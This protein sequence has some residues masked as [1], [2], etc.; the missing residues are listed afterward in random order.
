MTVRDLIEYLE[1]YDGDA[2]VR[3]AMQPEW[4][5]AFRVAGV[6]SA[7]E[8]AAESDEPEDEPTEAE[9]PVV[10][11]AAGSHPSDNPYAPKGAWAYS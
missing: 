11:I 9:E 4:P 7:D 8:I 6:M 1:A 3:L 5:L 2:E 10:W